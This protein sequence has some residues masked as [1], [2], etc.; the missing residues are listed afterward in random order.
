MKAQRDLLHGF[1]QL[2]MRIKMKKEKKWLHSIAYF[3][4]SCYC[5][6]YFELRSIGG[7]AHRVSVCTIQMNPFIMQKTCNHRKCA[8]ANK[9]LPTAFGSLVRSCSCASIVAYNWIYLDG[10]YMLRYKVFVLYEFISY[11]FSSVK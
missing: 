5:N 3:R 11:T 8:I 7:R 10:I 2:H 9:P 1:Y 6:M 4:M